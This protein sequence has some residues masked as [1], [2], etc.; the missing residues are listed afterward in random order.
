MS[1]PLVMHYPSSRMEQLEPQYG[2]CSSILTATGFWLL[3]NQKVDIGAGFLK[4]VLFLCYVSVPSERANL[5]VTV[6]KVT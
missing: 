2:S 6:L 1:L 3:F 5:N 4:M